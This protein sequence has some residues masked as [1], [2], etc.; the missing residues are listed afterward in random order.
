MKRKVLKCF[1]FFPL[2][3]TKLRIVRAN[4]CL[5]LFSCNKIKIH[6]HRIMKWMKKF[7]HFREKCLSITS[8]QF[9]FNGFSSSLKNSSRV[10]VFILISSNDAPIKTCGS[11]VHG[12]S[13]NANKSS[14]T[15]YINA[16][17]RAISSISWKIE[18]NSF[19]QADLSEK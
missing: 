9:H 6:S 4:L 17:T 10:S 8:N 14:R 16:L 5:L 1:S 18:I 19:V 2:L 7:S 13:G 11:R 15:F 3:Q 12:N